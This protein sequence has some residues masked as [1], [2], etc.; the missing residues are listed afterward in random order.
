MQLKKFLFI[1]FC[2]LFLIAAFA[3]W[4]GMRAQA[5][6]ASPQANYSVSWWAVDGGGGASQGGSYTLHGTAGQPDAGTF[7]GGSYTLKG[8][9][10]SGL[11]EFQTFI[12]M[13]RR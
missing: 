2:A 4:Q 11:F 13:V 7:T 3:L 12:P 10:W 8:G 1:L 6:P 5:A 9:F